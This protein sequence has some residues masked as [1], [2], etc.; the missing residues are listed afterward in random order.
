M[1]SILDFALPLH[2]ALLPLRLY[3]DGAMYWPAGNTVFITDPHFGKAAS[4][5]HAGIAIPTALL[6]HDLARLTRIL[7]HAQASSLVILG[8]FFHTR[9]S[10]SDHT[11]TTL[12]HWRAEHPTVDITL[13]PGN[14]DLHAGPPPPE[15]TITTVAD[16]FHV[17]PFVC[18]H[19][20]Q[21]AAD[22][23]GYILAGHLH[24]CVVLRDRDGSSLRLAS[25]I[26]G[27]HQ[28]VLPAFGRFT[29]GSTYTPAVGDR[30]F[31]TAQGE[32]VEIPTAR[33]PSP[34]R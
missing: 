34:H 16:P 28:A 30:V 12:T 26:F 9:H 5:Q 3:A 29:G 18:H 4:F 32:I 13:V 10:Q 7:Q 20:P 31:A 11:L 22:A 19:Q 1:P 14:H 33:S 17:G 15:L 2:N 23:N 6:E 25:F 27:R 8:D 24:P 21:P